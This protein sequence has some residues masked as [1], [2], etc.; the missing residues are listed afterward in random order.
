[1][2]GVCFSFAFFCAFF[3]FVLFSCYV[4]PPSPALFVSAVRGCRAESRQTTTKTDVPPR[5]MTSEKKLFHR[6]K[7]KKSR[8]AGT[9]RSRHGATRADREGILALCTHPSFSRPLRFAPSIVFP[10]H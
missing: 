10:P 1:M 8:P 2:E 6:V 9:R 4:E 7:Q 5:S 3:A